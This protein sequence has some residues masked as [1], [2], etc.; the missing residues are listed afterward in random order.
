V[1]TA[2]CQLISE[3][4]E[5]YQLYPR[6]GFYVYFEDGRMIVL[7]SR[8]EVGAEY[9]VGGGII[10]ATQNPWNPSG[11]GACESVV[12]MISGV[13]DIGVRKAVDAFT[14]NYSQFKYAYA[15]VTAD[16]EMVKVP[17]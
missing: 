5:L 17:W 11:I 6:L 12:W 9:R 1:G 13:D 3:L 10:Q 7:N 16:D 14:R 2:D 4:N 8:G 15:V